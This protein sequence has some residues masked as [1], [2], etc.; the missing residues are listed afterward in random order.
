[1]QLQLR[2]KEDVQGLCEEAEINLPADQFDAIFAMA[3]DAD[4]E[5][6]KCCMDT[7]FRARHHVLARM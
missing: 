2:T 1:M 3:S 5:E 4:G 7:F 6:G